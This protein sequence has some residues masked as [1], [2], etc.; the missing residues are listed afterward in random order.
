MVGADGLARGFAAEAMPLHESGPRIS[1]VVLYSAAAGLA[2]GDGDASG[3]AELAAIADREGTELGVEREL[4]LARA[5]LARA[6]LTL[7][8]VP[9]AADR[10]AAALD[11]ALAMA[12][13]FPLAIALETSVAVLEAAGEGLPEERREL[14]NAAASVRRRGDR[15]APPSLRRPTREPAPDADPDPRAAARLA[16]KLLGAMV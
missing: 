1:R 10:A 15:P 5:I 11:A 8:D 7:G 4:P 2:L 14:L 16:V 13:D 12:F 3:A 9:G 6:R